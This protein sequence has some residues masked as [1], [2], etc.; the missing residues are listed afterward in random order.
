[1]KI[2]TKKIAEELVTKIATLKVWDIDPANWTFEVIATTESVDRHGEVIM[3]N[4]W[5]LDNY[6]KNPIILFWHDYWELESV[7]W[8]ATS[9]EIVDNKMIVKWVFASEEA[10]P[11]AQMLRRLYDEWIIRTVSVGLKVLARSVEDSDIITNAELLEL[12]FVPVPANPEAMRKIKWFLPSDSIKIYEDVWII[13]DEEQEEKEN[14]ELE[15][16]KTILKSLTQEVWEIKK[17]LV[18]GKT[19]S[20]ADKDKKENL[21]TAVRAINDVLRD[22]KQK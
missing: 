19:I 5:K 8:K 4:G 9:V 20:E 6:L 2:Y 3:M 22:M 1:M 15:E 11:K 14:E 12:S 10:N 17:L 18:D 21:Q 7:V 16:V 13:K